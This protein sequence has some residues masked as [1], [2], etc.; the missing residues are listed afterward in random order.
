MNIYSCTDGRSESGQPV[1]VEYSGASS[2]VNGFLVLGMEHRRIM[3]G[4][5]CYGFIWSR[6]AGGFKLNV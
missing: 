2:G 3:G 5:L 4:L 6:N 1:R